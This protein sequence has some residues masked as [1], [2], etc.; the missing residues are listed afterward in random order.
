VRGHARQVSYKQS[1]QTHFRVAFTRD[2]GWNFE[3][4][5]LGDS[6]QTEYCQG[7]I[8]I[9]VSLCINPFGALG[10]QLVF[11]VGITVTE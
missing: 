8:D 6:S 2:L 5:I 10:E 3:I 9:L 4:T 1:G 11:N 7:I